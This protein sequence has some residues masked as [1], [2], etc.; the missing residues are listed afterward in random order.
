MVL[1]LFVEKSTLHWNRQPNMAKSFQGYR[2]IPLSIAAKKAICA[3]I[4]KC[5]DG[6]VVSRYDSF[7]NRSLILASSGSS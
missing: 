2:E 1:Y 6:S 7:E 3:P 5:A 4:T